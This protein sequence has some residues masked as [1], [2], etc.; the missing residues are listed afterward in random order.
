MKVYAEDAADYLEALIK[1]YLLKRTDGTAS[2]GAFVS[3]LDD[4][5]LAKFA[6]TAV[7]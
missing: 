4:E 2:F 5:D 3:A 7:H 1:Q 6:Q